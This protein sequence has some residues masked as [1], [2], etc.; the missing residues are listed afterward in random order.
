VLKPSETNKGKLMK[1]VQYKEYGSTDVLSIVEIDAPHA[2]PGQIRIAVRAAGVNPLDWKLR[3]GIYRDFMPIDLPS[4]VGGEAAGIVDEVGA[5]VSGVAVGDSVF[6][7]S[8]RRTAM[9]EQAVL[10]SWAH[11][12]EGMPFEVAGGLPTIAEAAARILALISIEPGETLLVAGAAGGV[13]TAVI[14]LARYRNVTVIGTASESKHDYLRQFGAIPT[15]YG[16]GLVSRVRE[17][18]PHGVDAALDLA[19]AGVIP[20][21]I[22][23]VKNAKRVLSIADINAPKYGAQV[24]TSQVDHPESALTDAARRYSEGAFSLPIERTFSLDNVAEAQKLSAT[25]R[26][27][28]KLVVTIA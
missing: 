26:V 15:T 3:S 17:L 11:M 1:A 24:T 2:G 21:L 12:P 22:E 7:I 9:A 28:G 27:A 4:G 6:G 18:A 10:T 14:Q 5:G 20:N 16:S 19:G 13:G 23:I 25:G 8:V